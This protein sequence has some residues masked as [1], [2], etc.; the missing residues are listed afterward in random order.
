MTFFFR[1]SDLVIKGELVGEDFVLA[2]QE[3]SVCD[4]SVERLPGKHVNQV[5]SDA[6]QLDEAKKNVEERSEKSKGKDICIVYDLESVSD[7]RSNKSR[8]NDNE[9]QVI[10]DILGL[11]DTFIPEK[12]NTTFGDFQCQMEFLEEIRHNLNMDEDQDAVQVLEKGYS[13]DF[14]AI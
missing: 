4:S 3:D 13:S 9:E 8:S 10:I 6:F 7:V 14:F 11:E 1:N 2:M 12:G 5:V